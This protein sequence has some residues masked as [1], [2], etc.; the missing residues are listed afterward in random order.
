[1]II[2]CTPRVVIVVLNLARRVLQVK[3]ALLKGP[4]SARAHYRDKFVEFPFWKRMVI[5]LTPIMTINV[6]VERTRRG[7][8]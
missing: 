4:V 3:R 2:T 6:I 5:V 1:M 8:R 7:R